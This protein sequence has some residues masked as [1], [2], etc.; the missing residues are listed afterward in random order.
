MLGQ[1][2]LPT[3]LLCLAQV[4][5]PAQRDSAASATR[6]VADMV[7]LLNPV[8]PPPNS[9]IH[10]EAGEVDITLQQ[11]GRHR[12]GTIDYRFAGGSET[13][14]DSLTLITHPVTRELSILRVP[15]DP[16]TYCYTFIYKTPLSIASRQVVSIATVA[17]PLLVVRPPL[18]VVRPAVP[19]WSVLFVSS[20]TPPAPSGG[21]CRAAH[22]A[23]CASRSR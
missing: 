18:G 4:V 6:T 3:V 11:M 16:G 9:C 12:R 8:L 10:L 17:C 21:A 22:G 13:A 2:L 20:P 7:V 1:T 19:R 5:M 23:V 14:T 15:V